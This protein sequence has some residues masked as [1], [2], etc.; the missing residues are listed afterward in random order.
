[1]EWSARVYQ[2]DVDERLHLIVLEPRARASLDHATPLVQKCYTVD[3]AK[4]PRL[5]EPILAPRIVLTCLDCLLHG[6][7]ASLL[8]QIN[9]F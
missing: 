4:G 3:E 8:K 9:P 5:N 1:M 2:T 7:E 6:V